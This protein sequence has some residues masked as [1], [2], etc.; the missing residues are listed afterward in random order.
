[1]EQDEN[2]QNCEKGPRTGGAQETI[3]SKQRSR[4]A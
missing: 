3:S 4:K 1:M 2:E